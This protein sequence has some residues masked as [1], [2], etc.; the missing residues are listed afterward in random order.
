MYLS[1]KI[2]LLLVQHLNGEW[3]AKP[4]TSGPLG[5]QGLDLHLM[6]GL[7]LVPAECLPLLRAKSLAL[8]KMA[9]KIQS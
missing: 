7:L 1:P 6:T 4:L 2:H 8:H 5:P 3:G 9:L